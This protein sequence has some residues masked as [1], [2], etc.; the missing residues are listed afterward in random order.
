MYDQ[1]Q[2]TNALIKQLAP[3]LYSPFL[4]NYFTVDPAP[5]TISPY[6]PDSGIDAS[7]RYYSGGGTLTNGFYIFATPRESQTATNIQATFTTIDSYSG[8][9]TVVNESR[10]VTATNGSF[11]D[12]FA[13]GTTVHIYSIPYTPASG[14]TAHALLAAFP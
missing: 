11:N 3:V 2:A 14:G 9:V 4:T 13:T 5:V 1:A 8:P 7:T 10:T 6:T 12:T